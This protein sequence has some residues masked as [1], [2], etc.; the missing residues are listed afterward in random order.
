MEKKTFEIITV[1]E[2]L[3]SDLHI[4]DY[5]RPY[6]WTGQSAL[7]L[8][9]DIYGAWKTGIP[10]YRIGSVVLHNDS[11]K[12]NIVDGQ[13]RLTTLAI[14]T[15]CINK[16][17][18]HSIECKLLNKA[19]EYG[20]LSCQAISRNYEVLRRKC[21]ELFDEEQKRGATEQFCSYFLERCT[22]V[23]ITIHSENVQEA[24]QFFD[25][26]NTRGKELK[27]HDLLKSYH[28][29]EM[30][31]M[32]EIRKVQLI[33][34]WENT[35][36]KALALLFENNLFPLVCWY[37][38]KDGIN[39]S[40]KDIKTF[41]GI[42]KDNQYHFS[43]YHRAAH[44]YIEK[45]NSEGMYEL[46]NGSKIEQFQ[47]TAPII[48]GERFFQ[49]TLHYHALYLK[50]EKRIM[51]CHNSERLCIPQSGS[52]DMYVKQL[53]INVVMLFADKF[54]Y[55]SLTDARLLLLYQWSYALRI[56]KKRVQR[57]SMNKYAMGTSNVKGSFNMFALISEMRSPDELDAVLLE[58][59]IKVVDPLP[60][61][62]QKIKEII[63]GGK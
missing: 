46:V 12:L 16:L 35:N 53:F 23:R 47:L 39:Y 50:I 34:T 57:E 19:E 33:N 37:R 8:L 27:P 32:P 1:G 25:S 10:E 18:A 48:A 20:A 29:R 56:T 11:L 61:K 60:D 3:E 28:L 15:Y 4:P 6:R 55:E 52:G 36:Q 59:D 14:I 51:E 44:L 63:T 31:D 45:F 43:V 22:M 42:R 49:Y 2:L 7:T 5:Q 38:Y 40:E 13:Q 30:D 58:R 62:Y 21:E 41:K 54:S 26:Q 17:A 24:F 9:N